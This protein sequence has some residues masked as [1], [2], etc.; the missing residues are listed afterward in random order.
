MATSDSTILRSKLSPAKLKL[1]EERLQHAKQQREQSLSSSAQRI[2][3]RRDRDVAPLSFAQQRLW[4]LDQLQPGSAMYNVPLALRLT[5]RLDLAAFEKAISELVRRHE[6]LRTTFTAVDGRPAQ[7][8]HPPRAL[9]IPLVDLSQQDEQE[10][11]RRAQQAAAEEA[12]RPFD[13]TAGPL[14][15]VSLL[16]L[17]P[18]EHVCLFTLHHI[19]SDGWSMGVFVKEVVALYGAYLE[20]K[21][22]P[23]P[24]LEVQ[25]ADYSVWQREWLQG[26][27]L[28]EQLAYWRGQLDDAPAVIELPTDRPRPPVQTHRGAH[29]NFPLS[30]ELTRRLKRL[31]REEG[32][33]LF[34]LLLSGWQL[35]LSR[36]SNQRDV[37]VGTPIANRHRSEVEP[38]IGFFV[39]TLVLR[40]RIDGRQSFRELLRQVR[41]VTLGAYAH[42]D[43]PF[44]KLVEEL[45][46]ERSLSHTPI[47]QVMFALQNAPVGELSLPGLQLR[48]LGRTGEE[49]SQFDLALGISES[50]DKLMCSLGYNTGLFEAETARRIA[51]HFERLLDEAAAAPDLPAAE[52]EMLGEQEREQ[53]RR[54]GANPRPYQT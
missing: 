6:V 35:L 17:A 43:F 29:H 42:Q 19:V 48:P 50:G 13:L 3:R 25:Y 51:G 18:E 28:E 53:L 27:V 2:P 4:F 38:L 33:S 1:L 31:G 8:I 40:A 12:R 24:E 41:E 30:E 11:E 49:R 7:L 46:P 20:G 15:R 26:E 9:D 16:R 39:N 54:W 34:M 14:L 22:S 45:Q 37:V 52:L 44:E 21:P 23:L 47:F 10:R 36:Y 32:A 5:G